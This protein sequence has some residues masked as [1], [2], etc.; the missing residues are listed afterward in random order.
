VRWLRRR[1][2]FDSE[3]LKHRFKRAI[4]L[5]L[6]KKALLPLVPAGRDF[7]SGPIGEGELSTGLAALFGQR[8][9]CDPVP[10]SAASAKQI[11]AEREC[12]LV[13]FMTAARWFS[14]VRWLMPKKVVGLSR[15]NARV[16]ISDD[17]DVALGLA[18]VSLFGNVTSLTAGSHRVP[19]A[20]ICYTEDWYGICNRTVN[21]LH[22]GDAVSRR[23][24]H[25]T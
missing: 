23:D 22:R 12:E 6:S 4:W 11:S 1:S 19:S 24:R 5:L 10:G 9:D 17:R 7:G 8:K 13:F 2:E 15:C 3:I 21:F 20:P 18:V 14:T 25:E 16:L